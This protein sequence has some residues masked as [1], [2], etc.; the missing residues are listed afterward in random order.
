MSVRPPLP[1][2]RSLLVRPSDVAEEVR[3]HGL[4]RERS[5][6]H[7]RELGWT[8]GLRT[9]GVSLA[10]I[11]PGKESAVP[12]LHWTEEEFMVVL[13]GR[14]EALVGSETFSIG[15]GD[16]LG[17]PALT[18][19]HHVRNP[20]TEP[21]VYLQGGENNHVEIVDYPTAELRQVRRGEERT[22]YPFS[23][24]KLVRAEERVLPTPADLH[25][26]ASARAAVPE[27]GGGH[28]LNP[29]CELHGW[30]LGARTGL[31]RLGINWLRVPPG[32]ES[33]TPHFHEVEEEFGYVLEGEGEAEIGGETFAI[34][35]GDF[36]GFPARSHAHNLRAAP[37]RELVFIAGGTSAAV[38]T[39]EFTAIGKRWVR[40][41]GRGWFYPLEGERIG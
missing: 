29:R 9:V 6:V 34:G 1:P 12:H 20:G 37:D 32:K 24:G 10:R 15:P 40:A 41:G 22:W 25:F 3:R 33:S 7:V 21:L 5:E 39:G 11:P 4:N 13:A 8:A 18:H 16:F 2:P 27:E 30:V 26:G 19:P 35:P 36:V 14:G 23:A 17:F 31:R 28:P 38:D